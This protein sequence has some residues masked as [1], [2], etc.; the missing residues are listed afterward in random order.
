MGIPSG[1]ITDP[2]LDLTPNQQ[3]PPLATASS[4]C[5]Q[6]PLLM[7]SSEDRDAETRADHRPV[8]RVL[9]RVREPSSAVMCGEA[10]Q[11]SSPL[12]WC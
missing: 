3:M 11:W 1:W 10:H 7:P 9:R 8:V 12:G 6:S 4:R 2:H 5:K